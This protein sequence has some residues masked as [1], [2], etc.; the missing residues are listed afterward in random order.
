[1][2]PSTDPPEITVTGKL[3]HQAWQDRLL[4]P[5]E[6][7]RP[8]LWSVPTPFP[9][10]PLRYVLSYVYE[11]RDGVAVIDTGWP[12]ELGW[13]GLVTG[14]RRTGWDVADVRAILVTHGHAD[15]FGLA[16]R[17]REA[18]GAWIGMHEADARLTG[19]YTDPGSFL[20]ADAAWLRRRGGGPEDQPQIGVAP[21]GDDL[22][23]ERLPVPDVLIEDR[24]RP[25]QGI[26]LTAVWTPGHTP[27]HLCFYDGERR[28][29][30]T[31]DHVLPRITPNISPA[32][33]VGSDTLGEYL[34]SLELLTAFDVEEVLPAHEYRFAGLGER[35][36]Q[37]RLHHAARLREVLGVLDDRAGATTVEVARQLSWS[38]PWS[39]TRG[40]IRRS[41]IGEAYAHLLHLQHLGAITNRGGE[42][43]GW[44]VLADAPL[45]PLRP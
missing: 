45:Q 5:V 39:Q 13:D 40:I 35:V 17:L 9:D 24:S 44:Y 34:A 21:P 22:L 8:G 12:T 28:V 33:S 16:R 19:S 20:R 23:P 1:M 42:V 25:F 30:L 38:R 11:L 2:T 3:Q 41:A 37:L 6:Q 18:S 27:G 15:H 26:D 32:P 14:L 7:V 31:G 36:R 4:P 29:M 43:D 10:N